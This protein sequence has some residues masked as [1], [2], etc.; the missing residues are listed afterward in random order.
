ML[1]LNYIFH[2]LFVQQGERLLVRHQAALRVFILNAALAEV[3][4]LV[5]LLLVVVHRGARGLQVVRNVLPKG[6]ILGARIVVRLARGPLLRDLQQVALLLLLDGRP[7]I[8]LVDVE[9]V[10]AEGSHLVVDALRV[11]ELDRA[12]FLVF[13]LVGVGAAE[14]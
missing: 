5:L 13:D 1:A 10:R 7:V 11:L 14:L 8:L 9:R 12:H 4:L 2:L 3:A 6:Q